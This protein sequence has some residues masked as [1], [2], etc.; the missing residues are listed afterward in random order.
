MNKFSIGVLDVFHLKES[1][2]IVILGN[3]NGVIKKGDVAY[4]TN[5]GSASKEKNITEI[6]GIEM[7][8]SGLV[9]EAKD[10]RISIR[11]ENEKNINIKAGTVIYSKNATA[12][13]IRDSY[14]NSLGNYYIT[15]R[16]IELTDD[17]IESLSV[18]D[19]IEIWDL[20]IWYCSNIRKNETEKQIEKDNKNIERIA[21]SIS[22]KIINEEEIYCAY[23]KITG[24]PALYTN[25]FKQNE[26]YVCTPS[27]IRIFPKAYIE[28]MKSLKINDNIE[29]KCI[30][31]N[32]MKDGIYKFFEDTFNVNGACGVQF[33]YE[34]VA[35]D[36]KIF[37]SKTVDNKKE[38]Y[39]SI[40][41]NP[42]LVRW[43]LLSNQ[44][45]YAK[46][47]EGKLIYKLY[48]QRMLEELVNARFLIPMDKDNVTIQKI[49]GK[50]NKKAIPIYTDLKRLRMMYDNEIGTSVKTI[51]EIIEDYDCAINM[52]NKKNAYAYVSKDMIQ[53]IKSKDNNEINTHEVTMENNYNLSSMKEECIKDKRNVEKILKCN[54]KFVK[55]CILALLL[56]ALIP[57]IFLE[58][59]KGL[60]IILTIVCFSWLLLLLL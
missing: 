36:S 57:L 29:L 55:Y 17:E 26:G 7:Q 58:S 46:G 52:T 11:I 22:E 19:C 4:I 59:S 32:Q 49:K 25:V 35:I 30:K 27:D 28:H 23:S 20:F 51:E 38:T 53:Q 45:E 43:M 39:E 8:E 42:K 21:K 47:K 14:I 34:N 6:L 24:E 56:G 12:E 9:Y 3:L 5:Y 40:I 60:S 16:K 13:E 10:S 54:S 44:A 15:E 18:T 50:N 37:T 41:T 31:N 48:Y 2:D 1:E 33:I